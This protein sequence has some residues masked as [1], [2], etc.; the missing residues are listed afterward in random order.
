MRTR[1]L[2]LVGMWSIAAAAA[3][4]CS[5]DG[6]GPGTESTGS[7]LPTAST[8]DGGTDGTASSTVAPPTSTSEG[9]SDSDSATESTVAPTGTTTSSTTDPA[10]TGTTQTDTET[11][12]G[13]DCPAN[14]KCKYDTCIPDLGTCVTYDDCPGDSYC[15][16]DG[17]CIPYGVPDGVIND[18]ECQ[19][20]DIPEGIT[21]V[22][23]CE[24]SAVADPANDPTKNSTYI[25]T[26]PMVADLNLDND[27]GKLQPSVIVNTFATVGNMGRIGTLRIFDGRTCELQL[28]AGGADEPDDANR[29]G[30]AAHWAIADLDGDVPQG[31][32]PELIGYHRV[33]SP[34]ESTPLNVYAFRI[35]DD[36]DTP[37]LERMWYG[38]NCETDTILNFSS[39]TSTNG[40]SVH[41]LDG[42]EFPEIVVGDQVFDR[43]GCV[44]TTWNASGANHMPLIADVDLD[45]LMDFV[46]HRR[47]AGWDPIAGEWVDKPWFMPA[48]QPGGYLAIA[49]AGHYS[50]VDGVEFE[51]APE[52]VVLSV[53]NS[54]GRLRI[55]SLTGETVWGPIQL[56]AKANETIGQGGPVTV[57]DFDGD[58][59][60]EFA[61][62]AATYYAVYDPDCVA[63][64]NGESPV[65]RPGG[66]CERSPAQQA[67]NLPDGVLWVQPSQDLSSNITGSSIFD[68][69]GDGAAEAVYRD[70]CYVRVYDG[71]SGDVL[72]SAPASSGTG[73]EYP[74]IADVDGDFATEI[75]VPRTSYNSCPATDPLYPMASKVSRPGFVIYRDP[76]DRWAN[77][78]P[79]W[80][81]FQYSI[82]HVTDDA[83][84]PSADTFVNNWQTP[85]LNNFRQNDQGSTGKL[86]IADLTVEL[87]DLGTLCQNQ[88]G[89]I[90]LQ[91]EVCNR[92]T[93]PV[94]DG[95]VVQFLETTDPNQP[96]DQAT[97]VC[98]AVTTKLLAP[99]ECETV[100]CTADLQGGGTVYVDVDPADKIADCHPGNNL[101]ADALDI[102]PG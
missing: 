65:E 55:Q 75:I 44:L 59:Q 43:D 73:N 64:L 42:D 7:V 9:G 102:C 11:T 27:P 70:E 26:T 45:G 17:E 50:V 94:Q 56:Y 12:D 32:R 16:Q 92:G 29:P 51:Q 74:S 25:Y 69:N 93:N 61:T 53:S 62:A 60:V 79:V 52:V 28:Q 54:I 38:R 18:P 2:T 37:K 96:V 85:G 13:C 10:V 5:D 20:D 83:R 40:P 78:R 82:T 87:T 97:V 84:V 31:G 35:V 101:G 95:V 3:A 30:Y 34:N 72:F 67:K 98:E 66:K 4:G 68:F 89:T 48:N 100:M 33:S 90:D 99:G 77:S 91:A 76:L 19:K 21:P 15:D 58:G 71:K 1:R 88:G 6:T 57:S 63:A 22:V 39:A 8:T 81:Q 46:N 49:N 36:G 14:F 24:W 41:D 80:N 23:Q 47:V 86:N